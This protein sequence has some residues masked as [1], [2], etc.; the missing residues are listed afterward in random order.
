L[1]NSYPSH[2]NKLRGI[3]LQYFAR[4]F[5]LPICALYLQRAGTLIRGI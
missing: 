4:S 1:L 2:S 5:F 3:T